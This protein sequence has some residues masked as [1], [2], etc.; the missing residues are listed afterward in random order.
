ME[1]TI[2]MWRL[3]IERIL[4][5]DTDLANS[6]NQAS[7]HWDTSIRRLGYHRAYSHLFQQLTADGTLRHL[8][9][10]AQVLDCGI[11]T[12][13]LSRALVMQTS[14][15]L[16][17]TGVDIAADMLG[18]AQHTLSS[19]Q[20]TP[21]LSCRN[22]CDLGFAANSFDLA[23]GAHVLEHLP[24]PADGL[25]EMVR[26]LRPGAPLIIIMTRSSLASA[27]LC[28]QWQISRITPHDLG[29]MM[30]SA[31]LTNVRLYALSGPPWCQWMSVACVGTKP[32]PENIADIR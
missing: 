23:M 16:H 14:S 9:G 32:A 6:Y 18:A 2:G 22:V 17:I 25:R 24:D 27:W 21:R 1:L 13:S 31:G 15:A 26:T 10:D 30:G 7:A 5:T 19:L 11:G 3:A 28:L 20:T 29:A 4:Q 12:G 8:P